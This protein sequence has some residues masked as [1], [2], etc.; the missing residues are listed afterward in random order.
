MGSVTVSVFPNEVTQAGTFGGVILHRTGSHCGTTRNVIGYGHRVSARIE[1][2]DR[3]LSTV[4]IPAVGVVSA[5]VGHF[6]GQ[7]TGRVYFRADLIV[8]YRG[9]KR[10]R[11]CNG[12]GLGSGAVVGV[13]HRHRVGAGGQV[14]AVLR[15]VLAGQVSPV[16]D[17]REG[18]ARCRYVDRSSFRLVTVKRRDVG[19]DRNGGVGLGHRTGRNRLTVVG[20]G[21]R[22]RVGAG[23]QAVDRSG[24]PYGVGA[25]GV[26]VWCG[27][28]ARGGRQAARGVTVTQYVL[29]GHHHVDATSTVDLEGFGDLTVVGVGDGHLVDAGGQAV[30][31]LGALVVAPGEVVARRAARD[32]QVDGAR[33]VT[34]TVHV[35]DDR[36]GLQG[37]GFRYRA[38]GNHLTVVGVGYRYRVGAG[39]QVFD[40]SG[41]L[42]GRR[43][44]CV[45]VGFRTSGHCRGQDSIGV[46][47]AE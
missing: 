47:V 42:R 27:A 21:Y 14:V 16:V 30:D 32:R 31:I 37:V 38:G 40:R 4:V 1:V 24:R 29:T 36:R 15:I 8:S 12:E 11:R 20:V 3:R 18:A 35:G 13:R 17:V 34:A 45:A 28:A 19:G 2:T 33:G 5:A 43:A 46:A 10:G 9:V 25:P 22:H 41:R 39:G 26:A 23:N 6:H 7:A 44:P